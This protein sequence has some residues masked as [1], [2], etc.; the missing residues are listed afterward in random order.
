MFKNS[1]SNE[2]LEYIPEGQDDAASITLED[3]MD[4]SV[5]KERDPSVKDFILQWTPNE[6]NGFKALLQN[7][8]NGPFKAITQ[9]SCPVFC[10]KDGDT[11]NIT[12]KTFNTLFKTSL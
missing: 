12:C 10:E 2:M 3:G 4:I 8:L 11:L 1:D 7:D 9:N 5:W 6:A